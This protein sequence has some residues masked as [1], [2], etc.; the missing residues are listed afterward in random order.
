MLLP[1]RGF[2]DLPPA[3]LAAAVGV[4]ALMILALAPAWIDPSA[5][6]AGKIKKSLHKP[7]SMRQAVQRIDQ[8]YSFRW[9][10]AG[11]SGERQVHLILTA[12]MGI[13]IAGSAVAGRTVRQPVQTTNT[14]PICYGNASRVRSRAALQVYREDPDATTTTS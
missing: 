3:E 1:R 6:K 7:T 4:I 11:S 2:W 12:V 13:A 8:H 9:I 10:V 14:T 5:A